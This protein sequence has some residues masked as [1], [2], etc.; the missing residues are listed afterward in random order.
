MS[1]EPLA[2]EAT[3]QNEQQVDGG[4]GGQTG[5][6]NEQAGPG[7]QQN[8]QQVDGGGHGQTGAFSEQAGGPGARSRTSSRST[9]VT[10][11]RARS[12]SRPAVPV[13]AAE[14]AAGR[15]W[16]SRPD[17]RVQRA[18]WPGC[19]AERAAGRRRRSRP[20]RRVQRAGRS[21][22]HAAE[23]AAGRRWS[24]RSDR[25]VQR[26]GGGP[27]APAE[28]AAGRR[29]RTV[30]P[31]RSASRPVPVPRSRTSSRSTAVTAVRRARSAS[32]P[33]VSAA[34]SRTS[35]RSTAGHG[36]QTGAF[37]EQAGGLGG[38]QQ[39]EQQVDGRSRRPDRRVQRAG[40][41]LGRPAE[42]AAGRRRRSRWPD[43]R[44]Q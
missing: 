17:G 34:R 31:V 26:A 33:A 4:N 10:V 7:A 29:R 32:R 40:G 5:A 41:G 37:N 30:R 2:P 27:A 21:R 6:F 20:D 18:G 42:R 16:R 25:R 36:G 43:R 14:R 38:T 28:R 9:A 19:S 13:H 3:Q 44:V 24:R 11:R 35:S 12:A 39:N 15:R 22:C 23:R 8:E 1:T